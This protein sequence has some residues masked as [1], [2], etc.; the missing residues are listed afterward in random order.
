MNQS[1][2]T[3]KIPISLSV[4]MPYF[5]I[6]HERE[7]DW[8]DDDNNLTTFIIV[9]VERETEFGFS[10]YVCSNRKQQSAILKK[11]NVIGHSTVNTV[12]Q[13]DV[14]IAT[15]VTCLKEGM[16]IEGTNA[17]RTFLEIN[18]H[19]PLACM[20]LVQMLSAVD[21]ANLNQEETTSSLG[22][23]PP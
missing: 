16:K 8:N 13:F 23:P 4:V 18:S 9:A 21:V 14:K 5:K 20:N 22:Y 17:L 7:L 19:R 2:R 12:S 11:Y 6:N 1:D 15:G 10:T 3:P